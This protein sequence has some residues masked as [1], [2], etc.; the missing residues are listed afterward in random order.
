MRMPKSVRQAIQCELFHPPIRIPVWEE[1]PRELRQQIVA[2]LS[3]LLREH[4][5]RN[6]A[7]DRIEEMRDE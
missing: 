4:G 2:L 3:R 7:C 1:L 6:R 5:T